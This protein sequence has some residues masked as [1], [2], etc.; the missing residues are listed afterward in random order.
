VGGGDCQDRSL[1]TRADD[2]PLPSVLPQTESDSGGDTPMQ[3][4]DRQVEQFDDFADGMK[5]E[6]RVGTKTPSRK[7][8]PTWRYNLSLG[9]NL[10][11]GSVIWYRFGAG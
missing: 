11:R 6:V 3:A 10:S 5:N 4:D 9:D 2:L 1:Y 8:N 7:R